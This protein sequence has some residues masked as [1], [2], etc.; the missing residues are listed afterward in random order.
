MRQKMTCARTAASCM[1][2]GQVAR[3]R[4]PRLCASDSTQNAGA[5]VTTWFHSVILSS[6]SMTDSPAAGHEQSVSPAH[7]YGKAGVRHIPSSSRRRQRHTL[8]PVIQDA[9]FLVCFALLTE[10][11]KPK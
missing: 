6:M 4:V 11:S 2:V 9:G 8:Q 5:A 1:E 3:M 7:P 10:L